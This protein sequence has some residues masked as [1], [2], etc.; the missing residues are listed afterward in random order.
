MTITTTSKNILMQVGIHEVMVKLLGIR[1]SVFERI[2]LIK[3][4][5][6]KFFFP[7]KTVDF[8]FRLVV[9]F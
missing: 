2:V 8:R 1:M 7:L 6:V 4:C 5:L 9:W 3:E